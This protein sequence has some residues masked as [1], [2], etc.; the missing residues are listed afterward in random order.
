M[1]FNNLN[2]TLVHPEP[3]LKK[4]LLE[5]RKDPFIQW[6]PHLSCLLTA[7]ELRRLHRRLGRSFT[8]KLMKVLR[9]SGAADNGP[10]TGNVLQIFERSSE[11][12]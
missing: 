9:R 11:P 8:D 12:C 7:V 5:T 1:Y 3:G 4:S 2:G 6:D 10:N